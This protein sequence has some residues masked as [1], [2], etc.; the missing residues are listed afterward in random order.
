MRL[1]DFLILKA[2][3]NGLE[4]VE[5]SEGPTKTREARLNSKSRS[6]Q[7]RLFEMG[8]EKSPL[9]LIREFIR[10]RPLSLQQSSPFYFA[11][12]IYRHSEDEAYYEAQPMVSIRH[13]CWNNS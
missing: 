6:F 11:I 12:K 7:A 8:G 3:G 1:D 9:A 10:R 13:H 4:F 2:D 5:N